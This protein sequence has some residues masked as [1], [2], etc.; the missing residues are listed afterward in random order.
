MKC[1]LS[2]EGMG[3]KHQ[4]DCV[5]W[6]HDQGNCKRARNP[7]QATLPAMFIALAMVK[8]KKSISFDVISHRILKWRTPKHPCL[9][10]ISLCPFCALWE[11][12]LLEEWTPKITHCFRHFATRDFR[13]DTCWFLQSTLQV[14]FCITV[15]IY[16]KS[17]TDTS[18]FEGTLKE[19]KVTHI[20]EMEHSVGPEDTS[21]LIIY[22]G[23]FF[24]SWNDFQLFF[25]VL[26]VVTILENC[27]CFGPDNE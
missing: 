12:C 3:R 13:G 4:F 19:K 8:R 10:A 1:N 22:F 16:Q 7:S 21:V 23:R 17:D 11:V 26:K 9:S 2:W 25:V 15:R 24:S 6:T 18:T 20:L 5:Y 14:R 27:C